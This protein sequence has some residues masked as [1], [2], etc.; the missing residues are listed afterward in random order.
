[1][2]SP[3]VYI[4]SKFKLLDQ[5]IPELETS[6]KNFVD[7]FVGG[8]SVFINVIKDY[9]TVYINDVLRDIIG[10][11]QN[12]IDNSEKFID[13]V[14]KIAPE[15]YNKDHFH[16][17]RDS[18]NYQPTP[19][20]LF[21]LIHSS[22]NNI[23]QYNKNGKFNANF[24]ERTFKPITEQRIIDYSEHLNPYKE[25]IKYSSVSFEKFKIPDDSMV[26]L[27]PPYGNSNGGYTR[28]WSSAHDEKLYNCIHE[29]HLKGNSFLLCGTLIQDGIEN[30]I[31][32]RL[33]D[34]GFEYKVLDNAFNRMNRGVIKNTV[35]VLI[36]NTSTSKSIK[37]LI[38]IIKDQHFCNGQ[39]FRISEMLEFLRTHPCR[40]LMIKGE[41]PFKLNETSA[42]MYLA[43]SDLLE[44]I[45]IQRDGKREWFVKIKQV[46]N[47]F[48]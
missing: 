1:M 38:A 8:G 35:E 31:L 20:K 7:L 27:D 6:H 42:G 29:I 18:Y 19:E 45:K 4:G 11:H 41:Y 24:G 46:S 23:L 9:Q 26:F 14:K 17:L 43:K 34:D 36:K 16:L 3:I 15:K 12:I 39:I 44:K 28:G 22:F 30:R 32:R 21:M 40:D 25:R 48:C 5:I 47:P 2:F 10:I 13:Y 33:I 37:K